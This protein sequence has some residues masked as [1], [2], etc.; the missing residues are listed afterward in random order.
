MCICV[1]MCVCIHIYIYIYI[2][3]YVYVCVYVYIYIYIYIHTC[4]HT[5]M[6]YAAVSLRAVPCESSWTSSLVHANPNQKNT[7][8]NTYINQPHTQHQIKHLSTNTTH[9]QPTYTSINKPTSSLLHAVL[10]ECVLHSDTRLDS[11][12]AIQSLKAY[13]PDQVSPLLINKDTLHLLVC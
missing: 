6:S 12:S 1:Y 3:V 4:T 7:T 5:Y 11:I 13:S 10:S 2:Y 9:H 8:Q